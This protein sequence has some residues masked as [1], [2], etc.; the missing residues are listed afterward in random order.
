MVMS[1]LAVP[2]R[3]AI[4]GA[5][6]PGQPIKVGGN[7]Y[8]SCTTCEAGAG[9]R[10]GDGTGC[11][12]EASAQTSACVNDAPNPYADGVSFVAL[13]DGRHWGATPGVAIAPD[14]T[15]WAFERCGGNSCADSDLNPIVHYTTDGKLLGQCGAK[16]FLS[17]TGCT[18]DAKGNIWVTDGAT[19]EGVGWQVFEFSPD[20]K[21]MMTLGTPGGTGNGPD[22]F[23]QPSAVAIAP[24]GSIFIAQGHTAGGDKSKI[25]KFSAIGKFIKAFGEKGSGPGETDI[26]HAMAFDSAGA[27]GGRRPQQ[28]PH[29]HLRSERYLYQ[30]AQAVRPAE[31]RL[32]RQERH[33]VCRRFRI[34]VGRCQGQWLQSGLHARH[35]FRQLEGRQGAGFLPDPAPKPGTSGAEGVAVDAAGDLFGAEVGPMDVE[36]YRPEIRRIAP[37]L[38]CATGQCPADA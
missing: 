11:A 33:D 35:P 3:A 13:P 20:G 1:V 38:R 25:M 6:C 16:M 17:R 12:G 37:R 24:D 36:K 18:V 26:P 19:K 27:A 5:A 30:R 32:H 15:V 9:D 8:E 23:N 10:A 7:G 2:C 28:Q 14:N 34:P 21:V 4:G 29:G 31:R 22:A